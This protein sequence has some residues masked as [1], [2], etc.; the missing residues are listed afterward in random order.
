MKN[1][2]VVFQFLEPHEKVP[3][4]FTLIIIQI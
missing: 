1:N 2:R 4:R 3:S